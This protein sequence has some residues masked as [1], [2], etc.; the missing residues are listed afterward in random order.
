MQSGVRMIMYLNVSTTSEHPRISV[1]WRPRRVLSQFLQKMTVQCWSP[2]FSVRSRCDKR[3]AFSFCVSVMASSGNQ[4]LQ[5][6]PLGSTAIPINP[7]HANTVPAVAAGGQSVYIIQVSSTGHPFHLYLQCALEVISSLPWNIMALDLFSETFWAIYWSFSKFQ[8]GKTND[9]EHYK[10]NYPP[11]VIRG[12][13]ITQI[14]IAF[15]IVL[16]QVKKKIN[17][18][19][20][21]IMPLQLH[22]CR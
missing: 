6:S 16:S 7:P 10:N 15:L 13:A 1:T 12:L 9:R 14:V 11:R 2:S 3:L 4:T 18:W 21:C 20:V 8:G 22:A 17:I 5:S 19:L